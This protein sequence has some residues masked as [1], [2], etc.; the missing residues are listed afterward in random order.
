L[1]YV[2]VDPAAHV[3]EPVYPVPPHCP[4]LYP[5]LIRLLKVKVRVR[6]VTYLVTVPLPL[7]DVEVVVAGAVV[8][9]VPVPLPAAANLAFT[10]VRAAW[11]YS[12]P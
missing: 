7:P 5:Q 9:P 8:V 10:N 1:E 3:V 4:H 11:P 12:V 6:R 2:Q